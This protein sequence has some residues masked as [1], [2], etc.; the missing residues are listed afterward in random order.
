MKDFFLMAMANA[1]EQL[2]GEA[3]DDE[4]VHAFFL[5]EIVHKLLEVVFQVFKDKDQLSIGVDHFSQVYDV[6]MVEFF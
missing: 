6:D 3:F 5:A 2:I 1:F 4:R